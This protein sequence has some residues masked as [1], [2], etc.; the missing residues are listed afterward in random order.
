VG[1]EQEKYKGLTRAEILDRAEAGDRDVLPALQILLRETPGAIEELGSMSITARDALLKKCSGGSVPRQEAQSL[2]V[3]E[4]VAEIAGP[5]PS[6]LEKLLAEQVGLCWLQLRLLE[7]VYAQLG[8]HS[9]SW[10]SYTQR[11]IDRAHARYLKTIRMLANVR[12]IR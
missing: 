5:N 1:D 8:E 2:F 3:Q 6:T 7:T 12:N 10:G 9:A 4:M 11:C